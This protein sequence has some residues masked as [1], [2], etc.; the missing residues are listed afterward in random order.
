[1]TKITEEQYNN[2]LKRFEILEQRNIELN[3]SLKTWRVVCAGLVLVVAVATPF[4]NILLI[5]LSLSIAGIKL[6]KFDIKHIYFPELKRRLKNKF[7]GR[8]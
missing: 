1:M 6:S 7:K 2:L 3:K 5:P 8:K 4:T